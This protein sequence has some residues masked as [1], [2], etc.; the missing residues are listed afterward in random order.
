ML[1]SPG[2]FFKEAN[3]FMLSR[4]PPVL[5]WGFEMY[6]LR[7]FPRKNHMDPV[8][9]EPSASRSHVLHFA[10]EPRRIPVALEEG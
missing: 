7:P 4:V 2:F 1:T 3:L 5:G 9:L 6:F 10:T 8:R